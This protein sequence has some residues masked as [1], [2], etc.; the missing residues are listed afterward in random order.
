MGCA[1]RVYWLVKYI[2][3]FLYAAPHRQSGT[4]IE[5]HAAARQSAPTGPQGAAGYAL[6]YVDTAR[7]Y[8][9]GERNN[10]IALPMAVAAL[11]QLNE[12]TPQGVATGLA[13]LTERVAAAACERGLSVPP[14]AHR[15]AHYIG[16]RG[17]AP[18]ASDLAEKCAAEGVHF[19]L[20]GDGIR[21]S[22]HLFANEV[23]IDRFFEIL[24]RHRGN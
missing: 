15:V 6:D 14:A 4:P 20:R 21:V 16:M 5:F 1:S 3:P 23:D 11:T 19:S 24:D 22:P 2:G 7:R 8:D 18:P 10:F 13:P 17:T 9:M 12:W